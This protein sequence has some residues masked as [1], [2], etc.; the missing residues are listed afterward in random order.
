MIIGKLGR[1]RLADDDCAGGTQPCNHGGVVPSPAANADRRAQLSGIIR[2]VDDVLDRDRNT[3][4][5]AQGAALC[6]AFIACTRLREHMLA[7]QVRKGFDV[8]VRP[9]DPVETGAGIF[10]A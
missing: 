2:G 5:R 1:H 6:A 3:M 7:V 9:R 4:E 8:A 10:L